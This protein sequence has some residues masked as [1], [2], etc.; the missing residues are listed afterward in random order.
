MQKTM[1]KENITTSSKIKK[2][3]EKYFHRDE[4]E[5]IIVKRLIFVPVI[6]LDDCRPWRSS[7]PRLGSLSDLSVI[8]NRSLEARASTVVHAGTF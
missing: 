6:W 1:T 7:I 3:H 4:H 5:K 2:K 8:L